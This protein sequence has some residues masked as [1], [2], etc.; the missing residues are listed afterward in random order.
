[1]NLTLF[2]LFFLNQLWQWTLS[3]E[4]YCMAFTWANKLQSFFLL[5]NQALFSTYLLDDTTKMCCSGKEDTGKKMISSFHVE[6]EWGW[7]QLTR[8]FILNPHW[9]YRHWLTQIH[10]LGR[11]SQIRHKISRLLPQLGGGDNNYK[12]HLVTKDYWQYFTQCIQILIISLWQ[13]STY[14]H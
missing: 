3:Y 14:K 4:M 7:F 8:L 13:N 12:L 9:S 2:F 6:R 1:M 11:R 10:R 5:I